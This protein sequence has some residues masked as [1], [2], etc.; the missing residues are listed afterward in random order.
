MAPTV[1]NIAQI[2]LVY[3]NKAV[4]TA[5]N[6]LATILQAPLVLEP[7]NGG[8][9]GIA[10]HLKAPAEL[11]NIDCRIRTHSLSEEIRRRD[12]RVVI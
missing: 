8:S 1:A 3:L 11:K 7:V 2:V 12:P 10:G 5:D 6:P 9:Y 4:V